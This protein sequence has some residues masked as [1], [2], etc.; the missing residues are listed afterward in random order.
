MDA[1][2]LQ[3]IKERINFYR[4]WRTEVLENMEFIK[5]YIKD[6]DMCFHEILEKL[7]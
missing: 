4:S 6:L 2:E 7:S 1:K 5:Q 3:E